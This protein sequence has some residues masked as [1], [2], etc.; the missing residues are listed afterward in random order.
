SCTRMLELEPISSISNSSFWKTESD[1]SGAVA[2]MYAAFRSQATNNLFLWGEGRSDVMGA[3]V[4]AS[5]F[6]IW[7]QNALNADNSGA[8][9]SGAPTNWQGMYGVINICNLITT[10][11]PNISFSNTDKRDNILAQA[12]A[13]RAFSYF[14]L[15]KTW[16]GVPLVTQPTTGE[17][18]DLIKPRASV[19]EIFVQ[20]K[21]DIDQALS[22]FTANQLPAG[23]STWSA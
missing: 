5:V 12:Y 9:F 13:M 6:E 11:A 23:R 1:A 2:G 18:D 16:G 10:Y 7:D 22:L 17:L 19:E 14:V 3:S 20:I 8:I 21:A 15:V 4:A